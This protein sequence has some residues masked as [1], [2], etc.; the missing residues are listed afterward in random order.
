MCKKITSVLL[1]LMISVFAFS[2]CGGNRLS[3]SDMDVYEKIHSYYSKMESY[4]ANVTFSVFS[5][6]TENKY[7]AE[8]KA[9][10]ND[11]FYCKVTAPD[12][13]LSVTTI[14]NG[15]T[16]KTLA[17]G[18]DYSVT[19]PSSDTMNLLFINS[20]FKTYYSSEE[21]YLAVNGG[22]KGNVT[23]LET[24]IMPKSAAAAKASLSVSNK[25]LAP[26]SL[27]VYD[28][29]GKVVMSAEFTN[30]QYNDKSINDSIFTTD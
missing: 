28:M 25:T 19:V 5:N 29:A 1:T 23:I 27:T 24:E 14:S 13:G 2:A 11:K 18:T 30:F 15:T 17:D 21:T 8:Q 6:K 3:D 16:T 20:F 12:S 10:G 7:T 9:M 22:G 26:V 4:S